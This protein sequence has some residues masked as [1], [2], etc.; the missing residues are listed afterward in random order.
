MNKDIIFFILNIGFVSFIS[1]S[2][3]FDKVQPKSITQN[4]KLIALVFIFIFLAIQLYTKMKNFGLEYGFYGFIFTLL[5]QNIAT[6][7]PDTSLIVSTPLKIFFDI[8][9]DKTQFIVSCISV[10]SIIYM[11]LARPKMLYITTSGKRCLEI[12]DENAYF[13]LVYSFVGCVCFSGI[14]DATI[15]YLKTNTFLEKKTTFYIF[16]L[17]ISLGLY[18][19]EI[20]V[21]Q[22]S[23]KLL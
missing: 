4:N 3:Y 15:D 12:F 7:I 17:F 1:Y 5:F 23:L 20:H 10:F 16:T 19:H 2:L 6:P 8:P 11:Y 13:V 21:K 9:M 22:L 18:V 14:L